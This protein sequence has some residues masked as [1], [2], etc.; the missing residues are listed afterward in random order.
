[1]VA[2]SLKNGILGALAAAVF[3]LIDLRALPPH[4]KGIAQ[5]HMTLNLIVVGLYAINAWL[6]IAPGGYTDATL[7]LSIVAVLLLGISGWLGGH[8]VYVH[9][10]GVSGNSPADED[11]RRAARL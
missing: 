6:R 5:K 9:D 1:M 7:I 3:G 2:V 4:V 10:A 11:G 8:M